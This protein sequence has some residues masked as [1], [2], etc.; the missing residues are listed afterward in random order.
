LLFSEETVDNLGRLLGYTDYSDLYKKY[1][2]NLFSTIYQKLGWDAKE[3]E[4]PLD[5]MLRAIALDAVGT[6]EDQAVIDEARKRFKRHI[7]GDL[8][9]PNIRLA[10]YGIVSLYGDED[11]LKEFRKLYKE[12]DVMEEQNRLLSAMGYSLNTKIIEDTLDFIFQGVCLIFKF[13]SFI[14]LECFYVG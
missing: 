7:N 2:L 10:V 13:F 8:I 6:A 1:C 4:N 12:T 11:T 3:S 5:A 14:H 9:D